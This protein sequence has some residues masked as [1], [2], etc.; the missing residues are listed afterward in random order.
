MS[1]EIPDPAQQDKIGKANTPELK[2]IGVGVNEY[3][4]GI[5]LKDWESVKAALNIFA[6]GASK[7]SRATERHQLKAVGDSFGGEGLAYYGLMAPHLKGPGSAFV[8]QMLQEAEPVIESRGFWS[9]SYDY[10][11]PGSFFKTTVEI[12]RL[13]EQEGA[14]LLELNAAY[15][16]KDV[17]DGLAETLGVEQGLQ[18]KSVDVRFEPEAFG[19][20]IDFGE[21]ARRLQGVYAELQT[22]EKPALT[23]RDILKTLLEIDPDR[24]SDSTPFVLGVKDGIEVTLNLGRVGDR[25]DRR[26][27]SKTPLWGLEDSVLT[28]RLAEKWGEE[29]KFDD[30]SIVITVRRFSKREFDRLPALDPAMKARMNDLASKIASAFSQ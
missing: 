11:G 28:G 16:G 1:Q 14:Y 3:R 29:G 7:G 26:Q 30:P 10:D 27:D 15:V 13:P 8:G 25:F 19:F 18:W 17:E 9:R 5:P 4:L 20:R 24:L 22:T 2:I 12:K 6:S 21:V 23:G